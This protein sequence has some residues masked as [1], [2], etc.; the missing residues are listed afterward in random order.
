MQE[1]R[2][3]EREF[4][5]DVESSDDGNR[6]YGDGQSNMLRRNPLLRALMLQRSRDGQQDEEFNLDS[7]WDS[8]DPL[9]RSGFLGEV[10]PAYS[11]DEEMAMA[12]AMS[13]R[14][15]ESNG[16]NHQ[17]E[18]SL[19]QQN[20]NNENHTGSTYNEGN[21]EEQSALSAATNSDGGQS[22][23]NHDEDDSN[24]EYAISNNT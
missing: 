8:R 23:R 20:S 18:Q 1:Q 14:E 6:S 22:S 5:S 16:N 17:S 3:N 24:I 13:L 19:R 11:E 10:Y 2:R 7:A 12:I 15:L 9:I 4:E 21:E